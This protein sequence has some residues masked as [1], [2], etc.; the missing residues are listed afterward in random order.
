MRIGY[1]RDL[2][3]DI[4]TVTLKDVRKLRT[5]F[6]NAAF[7]S[8]NSPTYISQLFQFNLNK[9]EDLERRNLDALDVTGE[10]AFDR[11]EFD[12][13]IICP[14]IRSI[15]V[16]ERLCE[17]SKNASGCPEFP[18]MVGGD[19]RPKL[20]ERAKARKACAELFESDP[21]DLL[22]TQVPFEFPE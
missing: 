10:P 2:F 6:E 21:D 11:Q 19:P 5:G 17:G 3:V 15:L 1:L 12:A 16:L 20:I 22:Y 14:T 9:W 4:D 8:N 18:Q 7:F 13:E